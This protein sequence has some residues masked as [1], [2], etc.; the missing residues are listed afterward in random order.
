MGI[1]EYKP[2]MLVFLDE[3]GTDRRNAIR[4]YGYSMRGLPLQKHTLL[5]RGEHV[6]GIALLSVNGILD[7]SVSALE[8]QMEMSSMILSRKFSFLNYNLLMAVIP[9]V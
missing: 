5:V 2:E 3:T 8:Q 9:T 7:V 4:R 6:S 1:M